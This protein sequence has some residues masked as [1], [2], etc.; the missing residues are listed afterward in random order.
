MAIT[1][2]EAIKFTNEKIRHIADLM[3]QLYSVGHSVNDEWVAR[4]MGALI[5]DDAA[6]ILYDSAYGTDGSDGDGR[7]IV[8]GADLNS[9]V[10]GT[11]DY[12]IALLEAEDNAKLK[13]I[14]SVAVNTRG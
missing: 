9:V 12:F 1:N 5:P 14:L 8:N 3:A 4:E 10:R 7:P 13:T 11:V 6:E 2:S